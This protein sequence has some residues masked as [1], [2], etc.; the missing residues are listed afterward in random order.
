MS[1]LKVQPIIIRKKATLE[2]KSLIQKIFF[3]LASQEIMCTYYKSKLKN[4]A[5]TFAPCYIILWPN[6]KFKSTKPDK[7]LWLLHTV[8]KMVTLPFLILHNLVRA[9]TVK[10]T[11]PVRGNS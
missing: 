5:T 11:F 3:C 9:D 4:T 10:M 6:S 1:S 8:V 2:V 7:F